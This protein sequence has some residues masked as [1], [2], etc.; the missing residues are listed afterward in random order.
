MKSKNGNDRVRAL[1]VGFEQRYEELFDTARHGDGNDNG[2]RLTIRA[3]LATCEQNGSN[4]RNEGYSSTFTHAIE[5]DWLQ[6]LVVLVTLVRKDGGRVWSYDVEYQSPLVVTERTAR[7]MVKV[8]TAIE[9]GLERDALRDGWHDSAGQYL[10]RVG[11][12]L[13]AC[14]MIVLKRGAELRQAG[15]DANAEHYVHLGLGE[16]ATAINSRATSW[17]AGAD[18]RISTR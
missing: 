10:A 9:K 6:D 18:E 14:R 7:G 12:A 1:V 4:I 13:G 5:P 11:R 16:G 2:M 15:Y 3:T 17:A 8:F